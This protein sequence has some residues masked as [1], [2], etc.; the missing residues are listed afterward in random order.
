MNIDAEELKQ[1]ATGRWLEILS[2]VGGIPLE[3]LDG[4]H[5][6]C[7]KCGGKDRFRL[8]DATAGAVIC[9][10][11]FSRGNGDALSAIMWLTG[12]DFPSA[13][14]RVGA[15]LGLNGHSNG[16]GKPIDVLTAVCQQKRMP[17]EAARAFGAAIDG[18]TFVLPSY[19]P[20]GKQCTTFRIWLE[21]YKATKGIYEKGKK[22]G[23]FF[24]HADGQPRLPVSGET[25]LVAHSVKDAV[26]LFGLGF[27]AVGL[28]SCELPNRFLRL[29]R[30]THVLIVPHRNKTEYQRCDQNMKRLVGVAASVK[31]V[32]LPLAMDGDEGDDAR[33]VLAKKDG[34][35]LLR[36][37]IADAREHHKQ[38][39]SS[40]W[41]NLITANGQTDVSN[42]LRLAL[43]FGAD[44][45]WVDPWEKFIVWDQ[46]RWEVDKTLSVDTFAR[47]VY[48][49]LWTEF[50]QVAD[51][52]DA[53][54]TRQVIAF[55]KA[56]GSSRG[57]RS[58]VER[59]RS[60]D[61][62]P[63]WPDV[64]DQHPNLLNLESGTVDLVTLE[65]RPHD[66]EDWIT[67]LCNIRRDVTATCPVWLTFLDQV[68]AG[69]VELIDYI[70]RA[71][72]YSL[73]GEITEHALFFCY[74]KGSNGKSTFLNLLRELVG[75]DYGCKASADLLLLSNGQTHPTGLSDLAGKRLVICI[76]ADDGKRLAESMVKE[77]TGGDSLRARRMRE[78]FWEFRPSHKIWLAANHKPTIRGLDDGIWRRI[79]LIPFN[80]TFN[81]AT[82]D[83][84]MPDR[85]RA[86]LP[87]I[88][89]W[90][91]EG[92]R[93]W[94]LSVLRTPDDIDQATQVYRNEMDV[95]GQFI[96]ECCLVS[97][98]VRVRAKA[99]HDAYRE[100]SG[101]GAMTLMKFGL[102]ITDRGFTRERSNGVWYTGLTLRET[103]A[104]AAGSSDKSAYWDK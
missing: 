41:P 95:L 72:G 63:I 43:K 96:S 62:I 103:E 54:Q 89:N 79:K 20:D 27:Y 75:D 33:D 77:M 101:E 78:D 29:F 98:N 65:E 8:L 30:G 32:D 93:K 56:T 48:Q 92:Y 58:M 17:I 39:A 100:W 64:L 87:G 1:A 15:H 28:P 13:L 10:Q 42:G 21:G 60:E 71:V 45:R 49:D 52:L 70:Q 80:V 69:N 44:F 50:G 104:V 91:I 24:P 57:I 7:P 67:Q 51:K 12:S 99:L 38:V 66:R 53:A 85:L 94:R 84:S 6:A 19:G 34:E 18:R 76:E 35:S 55:I 68:F 97:G 83:R 86:E 88:L 61:G 26:A 82:K 36:Q 37:A 2:V 59:S 90:A 102:A 81:E 11:C 5:H 47:N 3:S 31:R 46:R 40:Q 22:A 14:S 9:N 4:R 16:N 23:M 73:S 74:G 25:V